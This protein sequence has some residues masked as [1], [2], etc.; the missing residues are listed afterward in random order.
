MRD[1]WKEYKAE[2]MS[3]GRKCKHQRRLTAFELSRHPAHV[4]IYSASIL[5]CA[6]SGHGASL[7]SPAI[8]TTPAHRLS[9]EDVLGRGSGLIMV[10]WWEEIN[11]VAVHP[12][13]CPFSIVNLLKLAP[14]LTLVVP[15]RNL[16]SACSGSILA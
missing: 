14:V 15:P 7:H 1:G 12:R 2:V 4:A 3:T 9:F 16:F 5:V 8:R 13:Y 11:P 6:A 10:A